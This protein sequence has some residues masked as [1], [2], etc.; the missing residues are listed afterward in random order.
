MA[1]PTF[2]KYTKKK[3]G[4]E[5]VNVQVK[6]TSRE[7]KAY[8]M[9]QN[10]WTS[11]QYRKQ[12]DILKNKVRAYESFRKSQGIKEQPQNIVKMLYSEAKSKARYGEDYKPSQKMQ[13]I[14]RFSAYSI[15]KGRQLAQEER[16]Q[17]RET[18]KYEAYVS[19]RFEGFIRDNAGAKKIADAIV[20][21]VKR[22]Q[23]LADYADKLN[24]RIEEDIKEQTRIAENG[25]I[26][27]NE[28]YGSND[29]IDFDISDYLE[30]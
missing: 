13:Q 29:E 9:E 22:E 21:P 4:N 26:P 28:T 10:G 1:R 6:M 27:A 3:I 16:Y 11:D 23:A 12:Y 5:V 2:Y 24:Y 14:K 18:A 15:T 25:G 8:V 30:E 20:N 7:V 19:K 17:R